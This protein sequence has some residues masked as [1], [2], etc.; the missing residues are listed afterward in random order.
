V[1]TPRVVS[2]SGDLDTYTL[3]STRQVLSR[4]EEPCVIDLTNVRI[5]DAA[6]LGEFVRFKKRIAPHRVVLAGPNRHV[7]RVLAVL[8]F[9]RMFEIVDRVEDVAS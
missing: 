1:A 3:A 4:V 7:R 9:D 8:Q 6:T 5:I 2:L